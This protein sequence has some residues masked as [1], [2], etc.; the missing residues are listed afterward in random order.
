M[1]SAHATVGAIVG[2]HRVP[3]VWRSLRRVW[4]R[5]QGAQAGSGTRLYKASVKEFILILANWKASAGDVW[6]VPIGLNVG[7]VVKLGRLP[8]KFEP[9]L[10]YMPVHPQ[11]GQE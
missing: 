8:V 2:C 11:N 7:K 10:Q 1:P 5:W 3:S 9:G 6:T 4:Q